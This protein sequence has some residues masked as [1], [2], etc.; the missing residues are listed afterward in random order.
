MVAVAVVE[1]AILVPQV[2]QVDLLEITEADAQ[3]RQVLGKVQALFLHSTFLFVI[4]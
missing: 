3:M 1:A 2:E 4:N